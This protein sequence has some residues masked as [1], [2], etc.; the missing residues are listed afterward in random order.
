MGKLTPKKCVLCLGGEGQLSTGDNKT[1][2]Q[3]MNTTYAAD[4]EATTEQA[5]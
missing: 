4:N 1:V 2:E 5:K 3:D